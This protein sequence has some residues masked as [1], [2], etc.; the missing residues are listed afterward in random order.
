MVCYHYHV[1]AIQKALCITLYD[2][3]KAIVPIIYLAIT[4]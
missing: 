1:L 3:N 2:D 4:Y